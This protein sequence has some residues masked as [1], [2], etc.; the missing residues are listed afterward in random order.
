ML[1]PFW[2]VCL[3][4]TCSSGASPVN[5]IGLYVGFQGIEINTG[6]SYHSNCSEGGGALGG[7]LETGEQMALV[8]PAE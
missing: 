7:G 3:T 4:R 2:P 1:G 6:F 5:P 8:T